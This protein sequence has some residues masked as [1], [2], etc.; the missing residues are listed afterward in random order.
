[1]LFNAQ[2]QRRTIQ[3]EIKLVEI[4]LISSGFWE[5]VELDDIQP[6]ATWSIPTIPTAKS[7]VRTTTTTT[8]GQEI[9]H[10][11]ER[12]R[13]MIL[14]PSRSCLYTN[15]FDFMTDLD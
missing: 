1:S 2:N 10:S 9:S 7:T 3:S 5:L 8:T 13:V 14:P 12:D 15:Y 6:D 4:L 11:L